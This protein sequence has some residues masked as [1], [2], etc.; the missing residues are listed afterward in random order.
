MGQDN[1][2]CA[3][4]R[5]FATPG[6]T[7]KGAA[8]RD[9]RRGR[10]SRR[11]SGGSRLGASGLDSPPF[12]RLCRGSAPGRR[13]RRPGHESK[14]VGQMTC[15]LHVAWDE[16][17]TDYH[18]GPGH[19]LAPIR[20][21]LTMQLAHDFGLWNLPGVTVAAPV[22]AADADLELVHDARYIA[23][24]RSVSHWAGHRDA[25]DGLQETR[26]RQARAF[27]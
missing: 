21:E 27:G 13:T 7:C 25:S 19:P 16:R 4:G 14:R 11:D 1:R 17:L 18:F 10:G 2:G 12:R 8:Q 15:T 26:L 5:C 22:P 23:A 9:R 6:R 20:V 3:E 24:V